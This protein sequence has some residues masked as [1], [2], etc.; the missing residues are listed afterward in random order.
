VKGKEIIEHW[1]VLARIYI[2]SPGTLIGTMQ[3]LVKLTLSPEISANERS[4]IL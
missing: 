2:F 4:K 3:D 1:K